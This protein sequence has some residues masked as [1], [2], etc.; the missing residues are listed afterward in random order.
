M[1]GDETV[2]DADRDGKSRAVSAMTAPLVS[3]WLFDGLPPAGSS[4][5][6]P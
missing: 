1:A 5:S 2:L 3:C 6:I 4:R